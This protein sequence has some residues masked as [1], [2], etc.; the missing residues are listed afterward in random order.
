M[1]GSSLSPVNRG[2]SEVD[3][4]FLINIIHFIVSAM[5]EYFRKK[6]Q[7]S[8]FNHY[9]EEGSNYGCLG[10]CTFCRLVSKGTELVLY[11]VNNHLI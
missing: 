8:R 9:D 11:E 5:V 4:M 1:P 3:I 2:K 6:F 7:H 10:K